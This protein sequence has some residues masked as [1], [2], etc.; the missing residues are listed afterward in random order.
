MLVLGRKVGQAILLEIPP[1]TE[2]RHVEI[3]L[4]RTMPNSARFGIEA[5]R[6][7]NIA[8]EELVEAELETASPAA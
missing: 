3:V 4:R 6:D 7:I 1:S 5:P 8:R 2:T